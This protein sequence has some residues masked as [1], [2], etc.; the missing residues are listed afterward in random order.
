MLFTVP[1]FHPIHLPNDVI[2]SVGVGISVVFPFGVLSLID[3]AML[4]ITSIT[5]IIC[6]LLSFIL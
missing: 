5:Q 2:E 3:N 6:D 4:R 1:D